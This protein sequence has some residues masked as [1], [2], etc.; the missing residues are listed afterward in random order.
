MTS[1]AVARSVQLVAAV[2]VVVLL[3]ISLVSAWGDMGHTLV[4][5]V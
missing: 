2:G 4:A 1:M 3:N 5:E